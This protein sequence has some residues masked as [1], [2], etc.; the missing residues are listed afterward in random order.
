MKFGPRRLLQF[1]AFWLALF[2]FYGLVA[3]ALSLTRAMEIVGIAA[4]IMIWAF[5]DNREQDRLRRL[6]AEDE[7]PT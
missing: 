6:D 3:P 4:I 5:L 2:T 7:P 1:I